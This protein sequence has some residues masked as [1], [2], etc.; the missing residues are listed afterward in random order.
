[1]PNERHWCFTAWYE[2]C[3]FVIKDSP[4]RYLV[5]GI[6]V[7]PKTKSIHFQGYVEFTDKVSIKFVKEVFGD[8]TM[9]LERR[10]GS[11]DAAIKYCMKD[12]N[13]YEYGQRQYSGKRNDILDI[14]NECGSVTEVMDKY[15]HTYCCYRNGLKDIYSRKSML[16]IPEF[17]PL[18][19]FVYVGPPGTGKTRKA[20]EENTGK[21]Y[22]LVNYGRD[23]WFDGYEGQSVLIIDEFYCW[24][25]YNYL[26]ELLDGYRLQ[27]PVKG[28]F[29][30]K[31]WSKVIITS[32]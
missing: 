24:I 17:T 21:Y 26:L 3:N 22:K 25:K 4:I 7:C 31:N 19:V 14:I 5:Y 13:Y 15:P 18:E 20:V 27:L 10:F 12:G 28:G 2:P 23:I 8:N 29:V 11:Q 16:S 32:N 6:E 1:M 9:H 30:Y